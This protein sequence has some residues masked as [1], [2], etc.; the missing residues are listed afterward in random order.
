MLTSP[1][2]GQESNA[3]VK[4]AAILQERGA[5]AKRTQADRREGLMSNPS[6]ETTASVKLVAMFSPECG[7]SEPNQ[8]FYF[9]KNAKSIESGTIS[10]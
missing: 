5:S 6:Q 9:H 3:P 10:S 1:L 2:Y 8:E 7:T 4:P